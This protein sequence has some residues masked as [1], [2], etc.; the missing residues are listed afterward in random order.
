MGQ[1]HGQLSQTQTKLQCAIE[2]IRILTLQV[3]SNASVA[4]AATTTTAS[5]ATTTGSHSK[6]SKVN[7]QFGKDIIPNMFY[8]KQKNDFR[9]WAENS[10]VYLSAQCVGAFETILEW[11]VM[12]KERLGT[13]SSTLQKKSHPKKLSSKNTFIQK[14]F[15]P[16][17]LSSKTIS[18]K[19]EDNFIHDIFIQK[20]V[21][22]MTLSS[23]N[24]FVQ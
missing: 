18:S 12:E 3:N 5:T 8:G 17:T 23:K 11:L 15:H 20:R 24:S 7:H 22:P 16:K 21:H 1:L 6:M 10:A 14:H 2:Q 4:T 9:E 13:L 19:R